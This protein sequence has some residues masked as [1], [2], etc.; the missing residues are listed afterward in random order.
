MSEEGNSINPGNA[1]AKRK[2]I[3]TLEKWA[4]LA[5]IWPSATHTAETVTRTDREGREG[6]SASSK[7]EGGEAGVGRTLEQVTIA[8]AKKNK[9]EKSHHIEVHES[10]I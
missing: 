7:K 1:W 4:V 9:K 5:S 2:R 8:E 3:R 6:K 10:R